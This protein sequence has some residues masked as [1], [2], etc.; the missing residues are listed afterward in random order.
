[1]ADLE[2]PEAPEAASLGLKRCTSQGFQLL[3]GF[4]TPEELAGLLAAVAKGPGLTVRLSTGRPLATTGGVHWHGFPR[5]HVW[6]GQGLE[7]TE[8]CQPVLERLRLM[9]R[10]EKGFSQACCAVLKGERELRRVGQLLLKA[11]DLLQ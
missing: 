10:W 5:T 2:A 9:G 4:L 1:M 7:V 8:A 3:E 11:Y 6:A